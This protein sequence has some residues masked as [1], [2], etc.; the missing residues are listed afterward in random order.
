MRSDARHV[1]DFDVFFC[2]SWKDKSRADALVRLLTEQS[3]DGR[4]LRVFQDHRAL[5]DYDTISESVQEGLRRSRCLV[6][7]YSEKTLKSYY[8]RGE[9]RY[10]LSAAQH[11]DG[12]TER[13]MPI[14][15]H[16][17]YEDVRPQALASGRLPDTRTSSD[18]DLVGSVVARVRQTDARRFGDAPAPREPDWY[19]S[20]L[21]GNRAFRGRDVELFEVHDA[22]R[23]HR[24]P[25]V[26]GVPV[27]RVVGLGGQGKTTLA[28]QYAREFATDYP[29][30][31]FVLRGFGSHLAG[32]ADGHYVRARHADQVVQFAGAMSVPGLDGLDRP[33]ILSAFREHLRRRAQPY[34]WIIDD[35][36]AA[37]D[38][39]TFRALLAPTADGHTLVTTRY[40]SAAAEYPWGG[41][42]HLGALDAGAALSL[43][44]SHVLPPDRREVTSALA[45]AERLGHHA[46]AVAV[47]ACLVT[48]PE[49]GGFS[50]L[51]EAIG[52]PGPDAMELASHLGQDLPTGYGASIA[53]TMLRSIDRLNDHGRE[54]LRVAS[55]LAPTPLPQRLL[56]G[57]VE[58]TDGSAPSEAR[59]VVGA[60]FASA[61]SRSLA[62]SLLPGAV[63][64]EGLWTVHT[65]VSR[66]LR[67]A[68]TD[69]RRRDSLRQGALRELT[70]VLEESKSHFVHRTLTH[71]LPHV[72]ELLHSMEGED[73]WHLA[74]EASR[75][76]AELGDGRGAL[77]LYQRLHEASSGVLGSHHP[78]TLKTL[79]GLGIAQ[80]LVGDHDAALAC[81]RQAYRGLAAVLGEHD[82]DVLTARNNVAVT[83]SDLGDS[84]AARDEYAEIYRIRRRVLNV[85]H[86]DTLM[87]LSNY[88]IEVGRG[89]NHR[90]A[91]RLK[92]IVHVRSRAIHGERD[93][94]TLDALHNLAA[95]T[96]ALGHRSTAHDLLLEVT[97]SR[98]DVLGANHVDTL[99]SQEG[100]AVTSGS[101]DEAL[102]LLRDA[103][104]VRLDVQGPAH[105]DAARTLIMLLEWSLPRDSVAS[106]R[107]RTGSGGPEDDA[108][109]AGLLALDLQERR[110]AELGED[111]VET[112]VATC[113][114][115]HALALQ[116]PGMNAGLLIDDA[117]TGLAWPG[118][119]AQPPRGRAAR[120]S[121]R[122]GFTTWKKETDRARRVVSG[123]GGE[124][125]YSD[126]HDDLLRTVPG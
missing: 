47:A 12:S 61:V 9:L 67:F 36:P 116:G 16:T 99:T 32:R 86:A 123:C 57:T 114:L 87:A 24:E 62:E 120:E 121:S 55:L 51:L 124:V 70:E 11:L 82:P 37:L 85:Q 39:N 60:G 14:L 113:H 65:L 95:G 93:P 46:Q 17:R 52:T 115:A 2:Y 13:V 76:Y 64:G 56:E 81:K 50:G 80:G 77:A 41:E 102:G 20:P 69:L 42:V 74:N 94:R 38:E 125:Y 75:V 5:E 23:T 26:G 4:P 30:G 59:A 107:A 53:S 48:D 89:G 104:R 10:A 92:H 118:H 111:H 105:P 119:R 19:P 18:L 8:C 43:L 110:V 58:R 45:V 106:A 97:A 112:A 103:Y 71:H 35:L 98:R 21:V 25:G 31:V 63:D 73:I 96:A 40:R 126:D 90:L 3:L 100:A 68:D 33:A 54:V 34:L 79:A 122:R 7:L 83:L 66:T 117:V 15:H 44:T 28:E 6:V 88:A 1:E 49:Q 72:Q 91:H 84:A 109:L 78:I 101:R 29:G 27:A 108:V 22:L